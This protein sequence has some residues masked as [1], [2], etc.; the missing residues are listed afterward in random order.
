MIRWVLDT[1]VLVAALRSRVG[2]SH[3][4]IR[5]WTEGR[6]TVLASVPLFLEYE[7]VLKRPDQV[8]VHGFREDEID[9]LLDLWASLMEPVQLRYLWRPQ[10]S[11]PADEMV[12]ETAVNGSA[13]AIVT[14]NVRHFRAAAQQWR[15]EVLR[16][17]DVLRVLE[18][19]P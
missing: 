16:P 17:A 19:K 10:L 11:D 15:I 6:F 14:F 9:V 4:L 2:A 13:S 12:L 8:A 18:D 7:A 1:N 5:L 3:R